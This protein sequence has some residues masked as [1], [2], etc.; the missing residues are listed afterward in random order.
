MGGKLVDNLRQGHLAEDYGNIFFRRFCA[1]AEVR[2]E[3]DF[4]IDSIATLLRKESKYLFAEKTFSV[5]VKSHSV[6]KI[7]YEKDDINWLISQEL[8]CYICTVDKAN[9]LYKIYTLSQFYFIMTTGKEMNISEVELILDINPNFGNFSINFEFDENGNLIGDKNDNEPLEIHLGEPILTANLSDFDTP[10]FRNKTYELMR[11]WLDMEYEL[12]RLRRID[13][14]YSISWKTWE[15][16]KIGIPFS[17][18][19][20]ENL[21]RDMKATQH[22]LDRLSSFLNVADEN[23]NEKIEAFE[24][25]SKWYR[26]NGIDLNFSYTQ[27]FVDE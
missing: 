12:I 20:D 10:N 2:Q 27:R 7:K 9:Q 5:Q 25:I 24:T 1:V 11:E 21:K 19:S 13:I 14:G 23:D 4:G 18:V 8:P 26:S 3:D 22:Y 6:R 16:P 15:K 17:F